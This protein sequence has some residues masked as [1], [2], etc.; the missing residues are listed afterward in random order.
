MVDPTERTVVYWKGSLAWSDDQQAWIPAKGRLVAAEWQALLKGS[1]NGPSHALPSEVAGSSVADWE[2]RFDPAGRRLGVWIADPADPG[3]GR[4]SLV[5]VDD[6]GTLGAVVLADAAALPGFSLD[7]DRLAWSTPP[8][9]NGQGSLVTVYAWRGE[10]GRPGP[11]RAG[12]RG[13]AR[14]RRPLTR[15]ATAPRGRLRATL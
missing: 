3:T 11:Q 9:R 8:G 1:S 15:P 10:R 12:P 13:R 2:V 5:E 4:L 7:A 14:R 6:D